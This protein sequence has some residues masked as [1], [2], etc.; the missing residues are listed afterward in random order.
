MSKKIKTA[1]ILAAGLGRRMYPITNEIPKPLA[2]VAGKPLID[3]ILDNIIKTDIE[4]VVINS[5]YKSE[6]IH[7]HIDNIRDKYP[8]EIIVLYE[9]DILETGGGILNALPL[10]DDKPFYVINS[11]NIWRD[12]CILKK[13]ADNWDNDTMD[14]LL[15][16][17]PTEKTVGYDGKGDFFT[18]PN[19][20]IKRKGQSPS[21]PFVFVG[22]QILHPRIF[23]NWEMGKFS[24]S[25]VYDSRAGE[26]GWFDRIYGVEFDGTWL[27]VG[28]VEGIKQ[29]EAYHLTN[30]KKNTICKRYRIAYFLN[31]IK[32]LEKICLRYDNKL[33]GGKRQR[34]LY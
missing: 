26:N 9:K 17:Y 28:T 30:F 22:I 32:D 19:K 3:G 11:D 5:H 23:N 14:G 6:L 4:K 31:Q 20:E 34:L 1:M 16:I 33:S 8:F 7:Q 2:K 21:A 29:A 10:F 13:L 15:A 12:K 27:H 18:N 25:K 24:I